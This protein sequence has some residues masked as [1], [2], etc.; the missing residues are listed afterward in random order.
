MT[1]TMR[2]APLGMIV[3]LNSIQTVGEGLQQAEWADDIG[4]FAQLREGQH[5]PLEIGLIRD[6]EQQRHNDCQHLT[7]R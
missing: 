7:E 2:L 4:A 1:K 6:C 5:L 3:S